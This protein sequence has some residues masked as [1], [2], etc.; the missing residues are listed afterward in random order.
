[1][2]EVE[3]KHLLFIDDAGRQGAGLLITQKF[4]LKTQIKR[5][6]KTKESEPYERSSYLHLTHSV[7]VQKLTIYKSILLVWM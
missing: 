6:S 5:L 2:Q 4:T 1:M 3:Q 7:H